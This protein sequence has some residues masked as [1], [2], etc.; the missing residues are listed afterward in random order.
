MHSLT[1]AQ[2][3][4]VCF[5]LPALLAYLNKDSGIGQV[6]LR[7]DLLH[8]RLFDRAGIHFCYL[9][10]YRELWEKMAM[11]RWEFMAN[12]GRKGFTASLLS[13]MDRDRK[14]CTK[15][16][17]TLF[18]SHTSHLKTREL[19]RIVTGGQGPASRDNRHTLRLGRTPGSFLTPFGRG[20]LCASFRSLVFLCQPSPTQLPIVGR[21]RHIPGALSWTSSRRLSDHYVLYF[22]TSSVFTFLV[23]GFQLP[24]QLWRH[25]TRCGGHQSQPLSWRPL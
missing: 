8:D 3:M 22:L 18:P 21:G 10:V 7:E 15:C 4:S 11:R 17:T 23:S 9:A 16:G 25:A 12:L 13:Q 6:S 24:V 14:G 5:M 2:G 1:K 19:W 20:Q